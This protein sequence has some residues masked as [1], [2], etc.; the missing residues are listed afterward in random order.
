MNHVNEAA[1]K[2]FEQVHFHYI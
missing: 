2:Q 1:E